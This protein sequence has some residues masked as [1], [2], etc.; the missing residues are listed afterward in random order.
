[1]RKIESNIESINRTLQHIIVQKDYLGTECYYTRAIFK[2]CFIS[3]PCKTKMDAKTYKKNLS[4]L[5]D[6]A[7][8]KNIQASFPHGIIVTYD[9]GNHISSEMF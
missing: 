8:E 1:M 7:K 2:S 3:I 4:Q 9:H 6:L 5:F